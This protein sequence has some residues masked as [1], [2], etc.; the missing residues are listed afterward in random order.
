MAIKD[1]VKR[2][3]GMKAEGQEQ[4]PRH[5][6]EVHEYLDVIGVQSGRRNPHIPTLSPDQFFKDAAATEYAHNVC[7]GKIR[8]Y[9]TTLTACAERKSPKRLEGLGLPGRRQERVSGGTSLPGRPL[10]FKRSTEI[11]THV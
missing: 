5:K 6:A 4:T 10:C 3:L 8:R 2:F 9:L 1:I 7:M 11:Q